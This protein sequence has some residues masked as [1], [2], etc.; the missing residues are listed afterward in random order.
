M[1]RKKLKN[2]GNTQR[3]LKTHMEL[4]WNLDTYGFIPTAQLCIF[5]WSG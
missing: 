3:Y 4:V 1:K 2:S 5:D